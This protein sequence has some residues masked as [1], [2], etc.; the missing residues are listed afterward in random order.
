M[1]SSRYLAQLPFGRVCAVAVGGA[2]E[3]VTC[4]VCERKFCWEAVLEFADQAK[5]LDAQTQ[6][7]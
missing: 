7:E 4:G 1:S 6:A 5:V 3:C 2:G